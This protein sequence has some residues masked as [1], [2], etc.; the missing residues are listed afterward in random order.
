MTFIHLESHHSATFPKRIS[1]QVETFQI[2]SFAMSE[3]FALLLSFNKQFPHWANIYSNFLSIFESF[4]Y[5]FFFLAIHRSEISF[6]ND[7]IQAEMSSW[8][9]STIERSNRQQPEPEPEPIRNG[10]KRNGSRSKATEQCNESRGLAF[11]Y[12]CMVTSWLI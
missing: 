11:D 6:W 12:L 3:E 10:K 9:E 7:V 5:L 1:F 2:F 8:I 4:F